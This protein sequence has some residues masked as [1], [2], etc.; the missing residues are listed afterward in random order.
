[1]GLFSHA[2]RSERKTGIL[3]S[4]EIRELIANGKVRS[5][6]EIPDDQG[7]LHPKEICP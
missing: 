1:M 2:A 3:P 5:S 7:I 4:Q 6:A